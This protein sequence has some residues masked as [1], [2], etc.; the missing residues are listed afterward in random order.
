MRSLGWAAVMLLMAC[1]PSRLEH[2]STMEFGDVAVGESRA[3]AL[4]LNNRGPQALALTFEVL[5]GDFGVDEASRTL[6]AD[7]TSTLMVR[8]TPTELGAHEG[9][10]MIRSP[11]GAAVV[12]LSGR[13][14]GPRL[15]I[16]S[17]VILPPFALIPG[18][19]PSR[20]NVVL[21]NTGTAGSL[22]RLQAPRVEGAEL[23][24][25]TFAGSSCQPWTPP[26]TLDTETL[27]E[28][29]FSL[30][31]TTAG[32][33][34]W[35][36]LFPS[37][38]PLRPEVTIEVLSLVESFEA[39]VFSAPAEVVLV[40]SPAVLR[41]THT[42]PGTC[43]VREVTISSTP[44]G[45]LAFDQAEALPMRL[46]SGQTLTRSIVLRPS[47]PRQLSGMVQIGAVGTPTLQVPVR[48]QPPNSQ[49]LVI[50]PDPFDFGVVPRNCNSANRHF[51]LYNVCG[52]P[53]V[54]ASAQLA[55][56]AGEGPGGP[57]CP[58]TA[59]CPEF[60]MV[61]G[62][63][64]GTVIQPGATPATMSIKYRPINFGADTGALLVTTHEGEEV[65]VSLQGRGDSSAAQVDTF[66]QPPLTVVDVLV[67]VDASPSFVSKRARVRSNLVPLLN[68]HAG[69]CFD[70]RWG[71]AAADGAPDAGVR[72]IANDAGLEWSSTADPLFI[73]RVLSAFDALP[74]GSELEACVGPASD[75]A[76]DVGIR[77]G[78]FFGAICVTDALEQSAA[79]LA[80]LQTLRGQR[81]AG[82]FS[83]SA[84]TGVSSSS[85]GVEASDDG[86]HESL[87]AASNGA[88]EDIC[89]PTWGQNFVSGTVGCS[90]RTVFYLGRVP[91]GPL[92]VRI[93]GQLVPD[94]DWTLN[95]AGNSISFTAGRGP[96]PG[97][98]LQVSYDAAVCLP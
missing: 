48:Y 59:P 24:V 95:G 90:A 54:I 83:W 74:V 73:E 89:T 41:L 60:L 93:E 81:S 44:A 1:G 17:P 75:L 37:N 77:D 61:T 27:L 79:P 33:R 13:A 3:V 21:R 12:A 7:S 34:R 8:F 5:S 94:T 18:A 35:T 53:L 50:A 19:A 47:A 65:V 42:G 86:V 56:A 62:L 28:V 51:Q 46:E 87:V 70:A 32:E 16:A 43:L 91:E 9:L 78:G 88:R 29:P 10:L 26:E 69:G 92:E 15:S 57:N 98:T 2:E 31:A 64:P 30:L 23:C 40:T 36:V 4:V 84:I 38:D 82:S 63:L 58:G 49:C 55:F 11:L 45:F 67:M 25:G 66:W 52:L 71:I 20:L 72:L 14:Q 96:G 22:L 76:Q 85:C 39:C 97:Q 80:A 68:R 6:A